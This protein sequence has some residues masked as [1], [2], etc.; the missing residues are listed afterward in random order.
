MGVA[1]LVLG[2]LALVIAW[3]P[4]VGVYALIFSILGVILGLC[5]MSK[6]K[7]TGEG[8]G[9]S[10]AGFVCNTVATVIA[11]WWFMVI[12]ATVSATDKAIKEVSESEAVKNLG[13]VGKNLD[14]LSSSAKE[15]SDAANAAAAEAS[16]AAKSAKS[17]LS[18]ALKKFGQD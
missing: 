13:E 6:A 14:E 5:G 7:K 9:I 3:V 17:G 8:K 16:E 4:C 10:I 1:S 18:S 12:G 15:L 2:I 11:I